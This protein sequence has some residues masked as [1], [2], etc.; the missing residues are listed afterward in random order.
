MA[1]ALKKNHSRRRLAALTFLSNISLDGSHR[2]TKFAVLSRSGPSHARRFSDGQS[3][4][5]QTVLEVC[6]NADFEP[7]MEEVLDVVCPPEETHNLSQNE[8]IENNSPQPV[9]K[10]TDHNSFSSDSDGL[11]TPAKA[12]VTM[13]LEQERNHMQ[14]SCGMHSSFRER[15]GTTGSDY[16]LPERRVGS[17]HYKKRISHQTSTLSEDIKHQ[18]NSSNESIGSIHSKA[19]SSKPKT[20]A[21]NNVQPV[22]ANSSIIPEIT[23]ELRLM[24]RPVN[25][26]KFGDDRMVLVSNQH[27]PFVIFSAIP[28]NKGQRSSWSELRKDTCRRKNV[29]S[30]RPLSA[31]NDS[32]DPFRLLG[33]EHAKDGQEISYGQ[34]LVPSRQF[35]RDKKMMNLNENEPMELTHFIPNKHHVVQRCLSYDTATNRAHY[36]TSES[37]PLSFSVDSKVHDW[38]EQSAQYNPNLLDDPEL[39]AGK[40]RTL[41]TFTSYMASVIDYVRP[42]DLKKELNDKFKE[43][44]PHIQLTLSKLRS[45]K[46]E[47]RKIAKLEY[48]IDLLTVAMAYVYFEKLILRN[49]VTKQTRKLCAGACLLLAAKLNDVK[50][51]ILKS[52]IERIEGVFRL[53]RKDLITSEFAVLVALEFGL[54]LP[55]WEIFPHYQRLIYES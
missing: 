46:R 27:V 11:L 34:L 23:K 55:T 54:H 37:P 18:Y 31:I 15:T 49:I 12:A 51:D 42:S 21:V 10:G 20:K 50:G 53:N 44:F 40:H 5:Q 8:T 3:E 1:A 38:D 17:L 16:S 30:Q 36:I 52:L 6:R 35:Q 24:Q 43:K 26:C 28:Y 29:S 33:I 39:I 48:G 4:Q 22:S 14:F 7:S 32:I 19:Q 25:G 9:H 2:D 45:L 47:M 41:L 13:F